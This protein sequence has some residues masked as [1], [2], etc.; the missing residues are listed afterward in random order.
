MIKDM[1]F[2]TVGG[3]GLFLFGMVLMSEGLKKI[4]GQKLKKTLESMTSTPF[5]AFLVGA[6]ITAVIQASGATTVMAIGLVNAG[7]LTLRQA[8]GV[9]IGSN[10]GTTATAWIVSVS[11]LALDITLKG[12]SP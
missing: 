5:K 3:L 4:A 2:R 9:I 11:G 1:V 8:I 10:V 6:G 7:M 12:V